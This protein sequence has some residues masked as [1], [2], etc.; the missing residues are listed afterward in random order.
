ML[1]RFWT[2]VGA[3][4]DDFW[5]I[6]DLLEDVDVGASGFILDPI[7]LWLLHVMF[8]ML[9]FFWLAGLSFRPPLR[10]RE[11]CALY[12]FVRQARIRCLGCTDVKTRQARG[13]FMLRSSAWIHCRSSTSIHCFYRVAG[14]HWCEQTLSARSIHVSKLSFNPLSELHFNS[15][16]TY[17]K[18]EKGC[19][20]S[21]SV[22]G[23]STNVRFGKHDC[24]IKVPGILSYET[25]R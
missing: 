12:S 2:D 22:G 23:Q 19:I 11:I 25:M 13:P 8:S 6:S 14:M 21:S 9:L 15:L 3:S 1:G 24:G 5:F 20:W 4:C 10:L 7:D 16:S 18:Y 17:L